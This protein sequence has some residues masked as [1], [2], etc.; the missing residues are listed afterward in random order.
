MSVDGPVAGVVVNF[1]AGAHLRPCVE[2]LLADGCAEVVVVDNAST[3]GSLALLAGMP[4]VRLIRSAT[5][6]G[7]GAAAN[8]GVAATTTEAVL[9]CNPD[10][11]VLPGALDA[12]GA[13]LAREE[14]LAILGPR[15]LEPGG[16]TYPS[17]RAFPSLVD[18][19]GHGFVGQ[20]VADNRWTRRY[21]LAERDPDRFWFVDWVSGACF[22]ARRLAWETLDGFDEAYFMYVEEVDLCWRARRAGWTVGIEPAAS[23]VHAHGVSTAQR[24]LR[25]V[26]EH[27]RSLWRFARRSAR[28]RE[29]LA[30]PAVAVGLGARTALT[31]GRVAAGRV[32][33]GWV[34]AGRGRATGGER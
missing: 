1:N 22:L 29:R 4:G 33:T 13:R 17:A 18:S 20:V 8:L 7:Y 10:I 27:H 2:S 31:A 34:L 5:N 32:G 6:R 23:V 12:L 14:D 15:V 19:I 11:V 16:G 24:P 3:D 25:M 26:V 21:T 28:G 30:L 9:V